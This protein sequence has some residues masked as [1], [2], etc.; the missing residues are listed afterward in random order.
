MADTTRRPVTPADKPSAMPTRPRNGTETKTANTVAIKSRRRE[1][2]REDIEQADGEILRAFAILGLVSKE[3]TLICPVCGTQ[4]RK[5]V[6]LRT[7]SSSKKP[8]WTCHKCPEAWG[9]SAIDLLK[10]HGG[11]SFVEA[12]EE[13]LG[14]S[15]S[16]RGT[17]TIPKIAISDAFAAIVDVDVYDTIRD[18]GSL[19]AAQTYYARWH[20]AAEAVAEAGSTMIEDAEKLQKQLLERFGIERLRACGVVTDDKNGNPV[21]LFSRDYPVIEVHQAP[22]GHVVGMQFRPSPDRMKLVQAH[23]AWKKRWSGQLDVEGNELEADEA[24]RRAYEKDQGVGRKASY[25][26]PFLS[27]K[28]GTPDHLVGCG[29][30]RLVRIERPSTVYIVEGFKDLLA[31]RTIGVE[32]YAIPGT[33]VMPPDRSIEIL[34]MHTVVVMLDGDAAGERGRDHLVTYLRERG[35]DAKPIDSIRTGLDVADILVERTAHG[36]CTCTTCVAWREEHS[37]DKA[38]CPCRT[39]KTTRKGQQS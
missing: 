11:R 38:T 35:V 21:F 28:G 30:Q 5:K 22:S 31:A 6:E 7:S 12:V 16:G 23:K 4:K 37:Y 27:L 29:L 15:S 26:T 33:G 10:Q 18:A 17:V 36:G 20:I 2:S 32:A 1:F 34:G 19:P 14:V 13:L 39:C 3:N 24:W 9:G 25:I 8:Y